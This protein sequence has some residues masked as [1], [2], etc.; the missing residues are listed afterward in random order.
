MRSCRPVC[1]Q[2]E[3]IPTARVPIVKLVHAR[4]GIQCDVGIN[5]HLGLLNTKLLR[6]YT[7]LDQRVRP[8]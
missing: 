4:T 8:V 1:F 5:S 3:G 7:E 6:L 2:V